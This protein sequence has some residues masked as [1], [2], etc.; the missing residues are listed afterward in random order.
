MLQGSI[1]NLTSTF[2]PN[3][4][5]CPL[6][7]RDPGS[8]FP[9]PCSWL[10]PLSC[11]AQRCCQA[12]AELKALPCIT[13][14]QPGWESFLCRAP[15]CRDTGKTGLWDSTATARCLG[16]A[17]SR[18]AVLSVTTQTPGACKQSQRELMLAQERSRNSLLHDRASQELN[19]VFP[20]SSVFKTN[21]SAPSRCPLSQPQQGPILLSENPESRVPFGQH[22]S[23][24]TRCQFPSL[25]MCPPAFRNR[26]GTIM[27]QK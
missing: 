6:W 13:L 20:E 1:L 25:Q 22:R 23:C 18:K 10:P 24:P 17:L 19:S 8:A 14:Q 4:P 12:P 26:Q 3:F 9:A 27:Q 5:C 21:Q 16:W 11:S 2:T 7:G 15:V